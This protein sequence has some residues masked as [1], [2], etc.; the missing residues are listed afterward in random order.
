MQRSKDALHQEVV[1]HVAP[2]EDEVGLAVLCSEA[3]TDA[4][5]H[6]VSENEPD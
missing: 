3:S 5:K 6:N 4:S 1:F 2:G